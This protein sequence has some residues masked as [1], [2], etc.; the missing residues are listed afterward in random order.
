[1]DVFSGWGSVDARVAE[2]QRAGE[3]LD[4]RVYS[5][6]VVQRSH[7]DVTL[8]MSA[9]SVWTPAAL[10]AFAVDRHWPGDVGRRVAHPGGLVGWLNANKIAVLFHC[11]TPCDTYSVV[12]LKSHRVGATL[13][14]KTQLARDHDAMNAALI[15]YFKSTVLSP[16]PGSG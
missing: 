4:L 12:G 16:P 10:L 13:E 15:D 1:V 8:D 6:D 14:T 7:T 9:D 2:K 5:N 3:W 11:S